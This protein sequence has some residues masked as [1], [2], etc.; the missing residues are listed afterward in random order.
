MLG[1]SQGVPAHPLVPENPGGM[2]GR[3]GTPKALAR[4]HLSSGVDCRLA[5]LYALG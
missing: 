3:V 4:L 2:A 5:R 1:L